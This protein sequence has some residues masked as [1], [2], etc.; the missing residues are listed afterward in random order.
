MTLIPSNPRL[1][2]HF[3]SDAAILAFPDHVA[4]APVKPVLDRPANWAPSLGDNN[5]FPDCVAVGEANS[6]RAYRWVTTGADTAVV[7]ADI[8]REYAACAGCANT[9]EA[10]MATDGLDPLKALQFSQTN[11]FRVGM[12]DGA[13]FVPTFG[14][15][16]LISREI[17]AQ[18]ADS[19]GSGFCAVQLYG[20]DLAPDAVWTAAPVGQP[21]GGHCVCV[22]WSYRGLADDAT[23]DVTR[24]GVW[25]RTPTWLWLMT[26]LR[27]VA[28][29]G[30]A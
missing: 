25:D 19:H 27:F 26:R 20:E 28:A 8:W 11:G 23:I 10:I 6:L 22:G 13:P 17:V 14:V 4:A 1:G 5:R 21:V 16:S 2:C 9:P 18:I 15:P 12:D 30:W 24:W 3:P 29:V 7:D